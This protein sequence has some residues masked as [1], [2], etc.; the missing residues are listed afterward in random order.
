MTTMTTPQTFAKGETA[1]IRLEAMIN[2]EIALQLA[3]MAS[4][5]QFVT[6]VGSV[7]GTGSDTI[8]YR[9][10]DLGAKTPLASVADGAALT[11]SS[12]DGSYAD[13]VVARQGLAYDLTDLFSMSGFGS[14]IDPFFVASAMA[15][16]AEA[17]INQIICATFDSATTSKGTATTALS[18]DSWL[19]ALYALEEGNNGSPLSC[20]LKNKAFT[21]LQAA[22]RT[23]NN[24]FLAYSAA[25]EDMSSA[26]PQGYAGELLGV[27]IFR[28]DYVQ[29]NGATT[30]WV[31][32]MF[33]Q[34]A[35]GYATGSP[36]LVGASSEFRAAG[37]PLVVEFERN[38][39]SGISSIIGHLYCGASIL[40]DARI[41]K[42]ISIK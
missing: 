3:D 34:N 26:K 6:Y 20:V 29:E 9:T 17:R 22:L 38:G 36:E 31:N 4:L 10:T 30:A 1:K 27:S 41:C 12:M 8:R 25:T 40:E 33:S 42:L 21:Q 16:S 32:A 37:S 18:V 2:A 5:R 13:V 28:S 23:E 35:L 39:K 15:K 11:A 14:D 7:N 19:E 24:N